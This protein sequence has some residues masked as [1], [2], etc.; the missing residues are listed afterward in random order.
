MSVSF[1]PVS[2]HPN[3]LRPLAPMSSTVSLLN[4]LLSM[5]M[6]LRCQVLCFKILYLFTTEFPTRLSFFLNKHWNC[7][8]IVNRNFER[9]LFPAESSLEWPRATL[10][11]RNVSIKYCIQPVE[12]QVFLHINE[13]SLTLNLWNKAIFLILSIYV[14]RCIRA[15]IMN[16]IS[17]DRFTDYPQAVSSIPRVPYK[18]NRWLSTRIVYRR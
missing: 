3:H 6:T 17:I 8:W 15:G 11:A 2:F 18:P 14:R 16:V 1:R 10:R 7:L 5:P 12:T 4:E 13:S 9:Y